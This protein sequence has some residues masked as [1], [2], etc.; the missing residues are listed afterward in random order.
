MKHSADNWK[1]TYGFLIW[2]T[3][4]KKRY[5]KNHEGKLYKAAK[6]LKGL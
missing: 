6:K 1:A 2:T 4:S 3:S 5:M